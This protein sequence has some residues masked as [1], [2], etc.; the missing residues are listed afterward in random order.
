MFTQTNL[1]LQAACDEVERKHQELRSNEK[2]SSQS[3]VSRLREE[4]NRM[5]KEHTA[6]L[7]KLRNEFRKEKNKQNHSR[8]DS[9]D[10][11]TQVCY[12]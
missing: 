1:S 7:E 12:K 2:R 6:A 4:V 8:R 10:Y 3:V 11:S 5:K 9:R